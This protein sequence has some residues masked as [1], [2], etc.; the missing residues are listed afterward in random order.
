MLLPLSVHNFGMAQQQIYRESIAE[1][2]SSTILPSSTSQETSIQNVTIIKLTNPVTSEAVTS[3][4][5]KSETRESAHEN[6]L[7]ILTQVFL[8]LS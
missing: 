7:Q 1:S 8:R 2:A 5:A 6:M 4:D 3:P